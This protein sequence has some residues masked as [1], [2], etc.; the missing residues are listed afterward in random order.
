MGYYGNPQ[1]GVFDTQTTLG[2]LKCKIDDLQQIINQILPGS[3]PI[4]ASSSNSNI[5]LP[6]SVADVTWFDQN[7]GDTHSVQQ[8]LQTTNTRVSSLESESGSG[9]SS[10]VDHDGSS[11]S[12][13]INTL[14]ADIE[15]LKTKLTNLNTE[16]ITH[17]T[18]TQ[19][20]PVI[21]TLKE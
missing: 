2:S 5:S 12:T 3:V 6:I 1:N 9:S 8:V 21:K 16:E 18:G 17:I 13:I 7:N 20:F 19:S 4:P 14:Q 11:L 15:E 10:N